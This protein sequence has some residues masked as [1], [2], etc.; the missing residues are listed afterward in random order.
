MAELCTL[1]ECPPGAFLFN[2]TLGFKTEYN[3]MQSDGPVACP[4]DQIRWKV[5]NWPEAYCMDSGEFFWGGAANHEDR[6]KLLVLPV[7]SVV[8]AAGGEMR[9]VE[10]LPMIAFAERLPVRDEMDGEQTILVHNA[11][12]TWDICFFEIGETM[13]DR[14]FGEHWLDITSMWPG[15]IAQVTDWREIRRDENEALTAQVE[16][17]DAMLAACERFFRE[18]MPQINIRASAMD[19]N[20]IDA[21]NLAE[22]AIQR[23]RAA[24]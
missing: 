2:D 10:E 6:A 9:R 5:S 18:A 17:K 8:P 4:G 20:A 12:G 11:S 7:E 13:P 14:W 15:V 23:Y 1:A 16:A 22:L 3:A 24:L 21:W 19:A